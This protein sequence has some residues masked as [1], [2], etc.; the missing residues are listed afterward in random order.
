MEYAVLHFCKA[1]VTGKNWITAEMLR[2]Q[3]LIARDPKGLHPTF[4]VWKIN[5]VFCLVNTC[6]LKIKPL[7]GKQACNLHALREKKNNLCNHSFHTPASD[8]HEQTFKS[9]GKGESPAAGDWSELL[10]K[11]WGSIKAEIIKTKMWLLSRWTLRQ[12]I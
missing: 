6:F 10:A 11:W 5:N 1:E 12:I 3:D 8:S 2:L 4:F 7:F 9:G